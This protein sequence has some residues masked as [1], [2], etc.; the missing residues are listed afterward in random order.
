MAKIII[1][2]KRLTNDRYGAYFVDHPS[3][4]KNQ[5]IVLFSMTAHSFNNIYG[6]LV[7]RAIIN[8]P[9]SLKSVF[10]LR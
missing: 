2:F 9:R 5:P 10:N 4:K 7:T 3:I 1:F 6:R 8:E